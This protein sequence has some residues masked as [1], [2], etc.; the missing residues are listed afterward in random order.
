M[1]TVKNTKIE[2]DFGLT[3]ALYGGNKEGVN[4]LVIYQKAGPYTCSQKEAT[5]PELASLGSLRR[6]PALPFPRQKV[7]GTVA[8]SH[9]QMMMHL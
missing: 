3:Q 1:A 4:D 7:P 5:S 2:E 6:L 8:Y 9:D